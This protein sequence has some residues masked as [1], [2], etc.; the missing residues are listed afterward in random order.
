MSYTKADGLKGRQVILKELKPNK[1]KTKDLY[2]FF[3][4]FDVKD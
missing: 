3:V 2:R 4:D 1:S